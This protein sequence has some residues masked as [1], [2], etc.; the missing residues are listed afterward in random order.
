MMNEV[1]A[2]DA[3]RTV[4]IQVRGLTELRWRIRIAALL[5]KLA[6]RVAGCNIEVET[7][8]RDLIK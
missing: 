1:N 8:H 7:A 6:G 2:M 4:T 5:F 3:M